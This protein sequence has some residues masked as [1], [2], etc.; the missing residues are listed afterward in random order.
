MTAEGDNSVLMQ[1]VAKEL[2]EMMSYPKFKAYIKKT[3]EEAY[4]EFKDIRN[5]DC[6]K[7]LFILHEISQLKELKMKLVSDKKSTF[8]IWMEQE[9]DLIQS[10]ARAHVEREVFESSLNVL[11]SIKEENALKMNLSK[12]I[13]LYGLEKIKRNLSWFMIHKILNEEN[14][15]LILNEIKKLCKEIAIVWKDI[16]DAFGIPEHMLTAPITHN[17]IDYNKVDNKGEIR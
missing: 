4:L 5:L 3:S 2:L 17:W 16:I 8:E 15:K 12:I 10:T 7:Y 13:T 11:N 9:S 14:S 1:K 6:I